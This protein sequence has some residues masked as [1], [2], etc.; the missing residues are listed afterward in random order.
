M[1]SSSVATCGRQKEERPKGLGAF[2]R[3]LLRLSHELPG[4]VSPSRLLEFGRATDVG[5]KSTLGHSKPFENLNQN[6]RALRSDLFTSFERSVITEG[7]KTATARLSRGVNA[8]I[9]VPRN[10]GSEA[11]RTR[12]VPPSIVDV[13]TAL[14]FNDIL[15][16]TDAKRLMALYR[17]AAELRE[18]GH[19]GLSPDWRRLRDLGRAT[20]LLRE[21]EPLRQ[22]LGQADPSASHLVSGLRLDLQSQQGEARVHLN[23][24]GVEDATLPGMP[25]A[26]KHGQ[27][28][29]EL[30]VSGSGTKNQ[31]ST[32][33][34]QFT[35]RS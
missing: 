14:R 28:F 7:L 23:L 8:F 4:D 1:M 25:D 12:E 11:L 15:G 31:F 27:E 30:L 17:E 19:D 32:M 6:A 9:E 29:A 20:A 35:R 3:G 34:Q 13:G 5:V 18:S 22:K 24:S 10:F 16:P 26:G 33:A 21:L 2:A